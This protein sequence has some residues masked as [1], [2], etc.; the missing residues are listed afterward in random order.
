MAYSSQ[1]D[2]EKV[3]P[4]SFDL[5]DFIFTKGVHELTQGNYNLLIP[6]L[7]RHMKGDWGDVHESDY[8][9]NTLATHDGHRIISA[10]ELDGKKFFIM[11]EWDRT[12]TTFLLPSEY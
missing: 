6:F 12:T 3:K 8:I 5:G 2:L 4:I 1:D 9:E 7:H 11:T 10:Y